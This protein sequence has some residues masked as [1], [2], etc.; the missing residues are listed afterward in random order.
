MTPMEWFLAGGV[1]MWP[2]L[3]LVLLGLTLLIIALIVP[4]TES[5]KT[6]HRGLG[7]ALSII[8]VLCFVAGI[9][10]YSFSM[11]RVEMLIEQGTF[12]DPDILDI[13]NRET[14][15]PL[16]AAVPPGIIFL[17]AGLFAIPGKPK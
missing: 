5:I 7:I 4:R 17:V 10:G 8:A 9:A 14:K 6:L 11:A 16:E 3:F 2:I 1:W 13:A 15:V 12:T